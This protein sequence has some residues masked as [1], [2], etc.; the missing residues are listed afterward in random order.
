MPVFQRFTHGRSTHSSLFGGVKASRSQ[1]QETRQNS[2][3][4][5][6]IKFARAGAADYL[7]RRWLPGKG[8]V[9]RDG[10]VALVIRNRH[11]VLRIAHNDARFAVD[12]LSGEM[13][14]AE[15]GRS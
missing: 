13:Y 11:C 1:I 2:R 15:I 14:S 7:R 4:L 10:F 5:I 6:D 9:N 12:L 3:E 8:G